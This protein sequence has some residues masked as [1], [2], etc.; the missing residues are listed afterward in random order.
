L[1]DQTPSEAAKV[2]QPALAVDG[3]DR[4]HAVWSTG[5][6]GS[7]LYSWV[8]ARDYASSAAWSAPIELPAPAAR[9]R[10]WP[11]IV[12]DSRSADLY[13]L[14]A[15]PLNEQ[16]GIY[17]TRSAD[18]GSHWI[19]PTLIID[20]TAAQWDS[21]DK[22]RL[23]LDQ[24]NGTLHAVWLRVLPPGGVGR[25]VIYYA[26]STDQGQSW[27]APLQVAEGAVDWPRV[28]VMGPN[29]VYL[30]WTQTIP[31][32]G[33]SA[34]PLSVRGLF[35][36][37]GGKRWT[38]AAPIKGLEQVSGPIALAADG[39]GQA[40]LAAIGQIAGQE[41]ALFNGRWNGQ[42]WEVEDTLPL[43]QQ[44]IAGNAPIIAISPADG[45]MTALL[46][47]WQRNLENV[48]QFGV[49]STS[50]GITPGMLTPGPTFT[51]QPTATAQPTGT[52]AP[53]PTLRSVLDPNIKSPGSAASG[54]NA[55]ITGG[56]LAGGIVIAVFAAA[57]WKKRR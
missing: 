47:L 39:T 3:Q 43:S 10:S 9:L 22:P 6:N 53:T 51:P 21:V 5:T 7:I 13:A 27:S 4:V 48:G 19:T 8:H 29:Q 31:Q 14:Y 12:A 56:L 24:S 34:A 36:P 42:D 18:G 23:A 40:Y 11:D 55:L 28:I 46:R 49:S 35:S 1:D 41:S 38:G 50:R 45:Q 16:R 37:D 54:S 30:A 33:G 15:V 52:P 32:S 26:S 20:A 57:I 17:V 25:Q 44:A 2:V